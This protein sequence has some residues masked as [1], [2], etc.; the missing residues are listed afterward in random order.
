MTYSL[1]TLLAVCH[2]VSHY[3]TI[4]VLHSAQNALGFLGN[5]RM[6]YYNFYCNCIDI[7]YIFTSLG[8][9]VMSARCVNT[10]SH[11][12][13]HT[14]VRESNIFRIS[15]GY[16]RRYVTVPGWTPGGVADVGIRTT[17][18]TTGNKALIR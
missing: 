12:R 17:A 13:C 5:G 8:K 1:V 2:I 11:T 18:I 10:V 14:E 4:F 7:N 16:D 15:L 9:R 3:V 6:H